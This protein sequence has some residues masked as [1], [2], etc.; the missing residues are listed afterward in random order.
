MYQK[1]LLSAANS[2]WLE[3]PASLSRTF[4]LAETVTCVQIQIGI[5]IC[6]L[7]CSDLS[8]PYCH[9]G[10]TTDLLEAGVPVLLAHFSPICDVGCRA[11]KLPRD[12]LTGVCVCVCLLQRSSSNVSGTSEAVGLN[13]TSVCVRVCLSIAEVI[14]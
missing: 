10:P 8:L 2:N 5:V 13:V 6:Q 4:A 12:M 1:L 9:C 14:Q 11:V 3:D 7:S